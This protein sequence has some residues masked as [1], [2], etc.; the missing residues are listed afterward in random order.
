VFYSV[1]VIM[2]RYFWARLGHVEARTA[3]GFDCVE[4]GDAD[5]MVW[6]LHLE[7]WSAAGLGRRGPVGCHPTCGLY[8]PLLPCG[9]GLRFHPRGLWWTTCDIALAIQFVDKIFRCVKRPA[10]DMDLVRRRVPARVW[11]RR[12]ANLTPCLF[13]AARGRRLGVRRAYYWVNGV[14]DPDVEMWL[15]LWGKTHRPCV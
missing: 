3:R 14:G 8:I 12:W 2:W 4:G 13:C 15:L 7:L 10:D 9:T 5:G 6:S 1:M 11:C